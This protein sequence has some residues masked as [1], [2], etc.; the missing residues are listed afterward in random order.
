M[1]CYWS[2]KPGPYSTFPWSCPWNIYPS[3]PHPEKIHYP[4]QLIVLL[5]HIAGTLDIIK[6]YTK[7]PTSVIDDM[8]R[9]IDQPE[10]G[11]LLTQELHGLFDNYAWC[12]HPTVCL[13]FR[14]KILDTDV[15]CALE[16]MFCM[17]TL[18]IGF[19]ICRLVSRISWTSDST[20]A[21]KVVFTF[22]TRHSLHSMLLSPM[23]ST[24]A[25]LQTL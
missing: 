3:C 25:V 19:V 16:S 10:N 21:L 2:S 22:R 18:F 4:I 17:N 15:Q 6:H 13:V 12:L 7:L 20:I 23:F 14:Y 11:M 24:L 8:T 9:M 5:Q 1:C